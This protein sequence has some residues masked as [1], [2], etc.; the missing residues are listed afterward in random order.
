MS[1]WG[2]RTLA[3]TEPHR[4]KGAAIEAL[5][6]SHFVKPGLNILKLLVSLWSVLLLCEKISNEPMEAVALPH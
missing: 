6:A 3:T 2:S 5:A 4:P 1:G